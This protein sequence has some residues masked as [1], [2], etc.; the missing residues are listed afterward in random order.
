MRAFVSAMWSIISVVYLA[1]AG[2]TAYAQNWYT[3]LVSGYS[4]ARGIEFSPVRVIEDGNQL[5]IAWEPLTVTFIFNDEFSP[6]E[7]SVFDL[8]SSDSTLHSAVTTFALTTR[9]VTGAYRFT[10][11]DK[12]TIGLVVITF[13]VGASGWSANAQ[14]L[15]VFIRKNNT[16]KYY[17]MSTFFNG[18]D[19]FYLTDES[20][21]NIVCL[22]L[23][24]CQ[25]TCRPC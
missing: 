7:I 8:Q 21:L 16:I 2:T 11:D 6:A 19:A 12:A 24:L 3:Q 15:H 18:L 17:E 25:D 13:L 23:P 5:L 22:N 9:Y 4:A 20:T 14:I 10:T 1:V